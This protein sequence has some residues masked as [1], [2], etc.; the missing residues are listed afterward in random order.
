MATH[1]R[2]T[3][4]F[5]IAWALGQSPHCNLELVDWFR[6]EQDFKAMTDLLR[7]T[8]DELDPIACARLM[9]WLAAQMKAE[10]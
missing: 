6:E 2:A 4:D 5:A 9:Q 8:L 10:Q 3:A 1:F 7:S